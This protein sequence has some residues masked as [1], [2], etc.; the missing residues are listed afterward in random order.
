MTQYNQ[1]KHKK[2]RYSCTIYT[3][4]NIIKY[5]YGIEIKDDIIFKIVSY[6]EK[7]G[8]LLPKGAIFSII[9]P[10]MCKYINLKTWM[11]LKVKDWFI[12]AWLDDVHTWWLWAQ[13]LSWLYIDLAK[14]WVIWPSDMSAIAKDGRWS[15][16]NHAVK[17][18]NKNSTWKLLESW[19]GKV[20]TTSIKA[21]KHWVNLWIYWNRARTLVPADA[22][23]VRIQ[24]KCLKDAKNK[25]RFLTYKE[26]KHIASKTK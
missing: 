23:T 11:K 12:R 18:S 13:K 25:W 8:V 4:L 15:W 17:K 22:R 9:Y 2:T 19:G 16:H 7:I 3:M 6:M 21:L 26:F 20:Y 10:A 5:D 14:D 1:K 24:L